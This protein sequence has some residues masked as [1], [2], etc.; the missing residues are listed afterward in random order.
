MSAERA[1]KE[2]GD[3]LADHYIDVDGDITEDMRTG[4]AFFGLRLDG[5]TYK[6]LV[7]EYT[8]GDN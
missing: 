6:V 5:R 1:A 4:G 7:I 2:I 3:I 8:G